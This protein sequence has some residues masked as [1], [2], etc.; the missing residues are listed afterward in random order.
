MRGQE[1]QRGDTTRFRRRKALLHHGL[2]AGFMRLRTE[3]KPE[4]FG[5]AFHRPAGQHLGEFGD[6]GLG[7][8]GQRADGVEF[9]ALAR[10]VL[11]QAAMAARAGGAVRAD[12]PGIV[13]IQQH[14][15]V[16]HHRQQ[17]VV[18][19]AGDVRA[20]GVLDESGDQRGDLAAAAGD[21]EVVGPE[22]DQPFAERRRCGQGIGEFGRGL[23]LEQRARQRLAGWRLIGPVV[24]QRSQALR[25]GRAWFDPRWIGG[26][27][28]RQQPGV[29]VGWQGFLAPAAEA[30]ADQ[31][32]CGVDV[33]AGNL[34]RDRVS[35]GKE[36]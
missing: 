19:A 10:Q 33:H 9:Q 23:R 26:A 2:R 20:D 30:E 1:M 12:R 13:E 31:G 18:E 32:L 17:H 8:A 34:G 14:R 16:A 22:P 28:L 27:Q 5:A 3:A 29:R 21:G 11:V 7:I 36:A 25:D 6:V 4:R 35:D 24:A 15:R